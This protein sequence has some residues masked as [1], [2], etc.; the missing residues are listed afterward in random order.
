MRKIRVVV[1]IS[2]NGSNLQALIDRQIAGTLPVSICAV[3]S[4]RPNAY[5][6]TRASTAGIAT[7]VVNH[8]S[9]ADRDSFDNRLI[10]TIDS[11]KP[12]LIV[13]AGF[14]RILT[15]EFVRH[16]HGKLMNIH[17]S[18]LPDYRGLNTHQRAIAAGEKHHGATVHFVTVELD[19]GPLIVQ[20]RLPID[21]TE[22]AASLARKVQDIEHQIYPLAI[23]WY[24]EGRLKMQGDKAF[25]DG[26]PLDAPID[27]AEVSNE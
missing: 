17:P 7:E 18:L 8:Q 21:E 23:K 16:Y 19:G 26:K 2:G 15:P 6:L 5:G 27:Y 3:I 1:L 12:D 10:E 9:Y 14:M 4:N 11:Y 24:A 22:V 25:L 13:L 20:A